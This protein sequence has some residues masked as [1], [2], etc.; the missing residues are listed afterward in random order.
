MRVLSLTL[1]ASVALL[2][3]CGPGAKERVASPEGRIAPFT[4][5]L[6]GTT[7]IV[8]DRPD[9]H[10]AI[11]Y[12]DWI[13]PTLHIRVCFGAGKDSVPECEGLGAP[14]VNSN[15][16]STFVTTRA[17]SYSLITEKPDSAG[18]PPVP[19]ITLVGDQIDTD[20]GGGRR[21]LRANPC[22]TRGAGK[23]VNH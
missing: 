2:I 8:P 4:M 15:G 1:L 22:S 11:F 19:L 9:L 14:L 6:D 12:E 7:W 3:A 17:A 21:S 23:T 13:S 10:Q 5:L 20:I 16:V 18:P